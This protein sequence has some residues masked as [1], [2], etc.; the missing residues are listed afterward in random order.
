MD[1]Y[2]I[3]HLESARRLPHLP[4]DHPCS[5]V[6]GHSFKVEVHLSGPLHAELGWVLDFAEVEQAWAPV[7][8]ALDHR[9]L[10]EVTGLENPTSEHLA[11]WIWQHLKPAL[12]YLSK[13][14]V[15][16]T[17]TSGCIYRGE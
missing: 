12:P 13:I 3:F 16:E 10:N 1:I 14:V 11:I 2:N 6:H 8:A 7:K 15:Q 9:Y 4:A 17:A 5:R